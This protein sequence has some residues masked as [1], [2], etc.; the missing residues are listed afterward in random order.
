MAR[1]DKKV[2]L[3]PRLFT[4]SLIYN[5]RKIKSKRSEGEGEGEPETR[6][7][8]GGETKETR[9]TKNRN[10]VSVFISV[11]TPPQ[12]RQSSRFTLA[13]SSRNSNRVFNDWIKIHEDGG[14]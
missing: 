10:T 13:P 4:A 9:Q 14:M 1:E 5:A 2:I 8:G 6:R 7:G 12:P 3:Q 11:L